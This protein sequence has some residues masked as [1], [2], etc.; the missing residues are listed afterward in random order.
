VRDNLGKWALAKI[1]AKTDAFFAVSF[2]GFSSEWDERISITDFYVRI[3]PPYYYTLKR[4][5]KF[6]LNPFKIHDEVYCYKVEMGWKK[7]RVTQID[8]KQV[9]VYFLYQGQMIQRW[10]IAE[11]EI[12]LF[13]RV[14][15]SNNIFTEGPPPPPPLPPPLPPTSSRFDQTE[16]DDTKPWN[17]L[18]QGPPPPPPT[19]PHLP[20]PTPSRSLA[21]EETKPWHSPSQS[22]P[23]GFSLAQSYRYGAPTR[24]QLVAWRKTVFPPLACLWF[25][26]CGCAWLGYVFTTMPPRVGQRLPQF[27]IFI[28]LICFPASVVC[29][30]C[31]VALIRRSKDDSYSNSYGTEVDGGGGG[32]S[33]CGGGGGCGGS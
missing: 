12:Q 19:P 31:I 21:T 32:S 26:I 6:S 4:G 10:F 2:P 30:C 11:L 14:I 24:S 33:G 25:T 23:L 29:C 17:S 7:G 18:T 13:R 8:G 16:E 15:D 27:A 9:Q 5:E 22:I 1:G 3:A 20:P 28:A